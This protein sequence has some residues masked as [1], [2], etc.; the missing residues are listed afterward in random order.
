[1]MMHFLGGLTI[2]LIFILVFYFS[3][4][5]KDQISIERSLVVKTFIFVMLVGIGWEIFEYAFDIANPNHG[6][7][8]EDTTL[9][10]VFDAL[11]ALTAGLIGKYK[12]F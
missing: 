12:R 6:N 3:G 10:L 1:M 11:G 9:D 2:G 8:I 4:F 7:Y 5:T